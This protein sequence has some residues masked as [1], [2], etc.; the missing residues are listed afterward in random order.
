VQ[1]PLTKKEAEGAMGLQ[2]DEF[3]QKLFPYVDYDV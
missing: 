1:K 3:I 2:I